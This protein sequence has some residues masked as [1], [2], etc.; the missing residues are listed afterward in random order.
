MTALI[1]LSIFTVNFACI[2]A[3]PYMVIMQFAAV[4][5]MRF[6]ILEKN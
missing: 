1:S 5:L 2:G 3:A 4:A 6:V